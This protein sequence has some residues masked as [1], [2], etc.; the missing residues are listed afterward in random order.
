MTKL[1]ALI[2]AYFFLFL[3]FIGV[4]LP[5]LPTVP[6]LLLAA[7]LSAKGSERLHK[8]IYAHA[9]LGP[10]LIN[11]ERYG[12]ISRKS[13]IIAVLMLI[14]SLFF[15]YQRVEVVWLLVGVT[16]LFICVA[17]FLITRPEPSE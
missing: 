9:I 1:F 16:V 12:T 3:A 17:T 10:L 4:F 6:F 2:F 11:W 5:G 8:W 15:M 7:W 14:V 13:K